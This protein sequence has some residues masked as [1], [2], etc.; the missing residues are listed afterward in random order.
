MAW[1]E[2]LKGEQIKTLLVGNTLFAE[3]M[4]AKRHERKVWF[5]FKDD[6]EVLSLNQ[7]ERAKGW[8]ENKEKRNWSV[9]PEGK[10]CWKAVIFGSNEDNCWDG[11]RLENGDLVLK[12]ISGPAGRDR[13]FKLMKGNPM[14]L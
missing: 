8:N 7:N 6:R 11:I 1:A 4:N 3:W 14:K 10:L 9:T 5:Y 12:G 2:G 13:K